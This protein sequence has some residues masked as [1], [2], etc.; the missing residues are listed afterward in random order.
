MTYII[1]ILVIIFDILS[2]NYIEGHEALHSFEVIKN[3]F[4]ITY[5]KNTGMAWSLLSNQTLLLTIVSVVVVI[6]I[7]YYIQTNKLNTIYKIIY[8]FILG[9]A[10][11]NLYD[12]IMFQYVRDFLDFYIFGYNFP[13]FNIADSA[14]TIGILLLLIQFIREEK[15]DKTKM[16]S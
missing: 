5:V 13:V 14:L 8:G 7:I 2:K 11:G 4:N 9:G 10:L 15:H 12:R 16:D 1:A 3:F 6:F